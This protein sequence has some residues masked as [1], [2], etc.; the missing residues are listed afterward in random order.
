MPSAVAVLGLPGMITVK[1]AAEKI[2]PGAANGQAGTQRGPYSISRAH[3]RAFGGVFQS[4]RAPENRPPGCLLSSGPPSLAS[5]AR[6]QVSSGVRGCAVA[7]GLPITMPPRN[8][9]CASVIAGEVI[10]GRPNSDCDL[11]SMAG[12]HLVLSLGLIV[13]GACRKSNQ[14]PGSHDRVLRL[15]LRHVWPC[16]NFGQTFPSL[17]LRVVILSTSFPLIGD[18]RDSDLRLRHGRSSATLAGRPVGPDRLATRLNLLRSR[19][20]IGC[21]IVVI[22]A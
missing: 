19:Q 15:T 2:I 14:N 21:V 17:L 5:F 9:R 6:V 7:P 12:T 18:H 11:S 8:W 10:T 1:G 13:L 22:H 16:R 3:T 20:V 4:T